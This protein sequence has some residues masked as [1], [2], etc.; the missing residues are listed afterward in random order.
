MSVRA[1][2]I[3]LS[4]SALC[5]G[6]ATAE[7]ATLAESLRGVLNERDLQISI[8]AVSPLTT[9][10]TR[11]DASTFDKRLESS[12]PDATV[13]I[14][15][16]GLVRRAVQALASEEWVRAD[17]QPDVRYRIEIRARNTVLVLHVDAQGVLCYRGESL[18]SRRAGW[19]RRFQQVL[20]RELLPPAD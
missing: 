14:A 18:V 8:F 4:L 6:I 20:G 9:T 16:V 3:L 1:V 10:R 17:R 19:M 11:L 5:S 13:T 2:T 7:A 15:A 12:P